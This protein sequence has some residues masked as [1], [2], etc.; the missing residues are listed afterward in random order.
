MLFCASSE[1]RPRRC[2][3]YDSCTLLHCC[4]STFVSSGLWS[5]DPDGM[6]SE[7]TCSRAPADKPP[8]AE[9]D[10]ARAPPGFPVPSP[11]F[12]PWAPLSPASAGYAHS[13]AIRSISPAIRSIICRLVALYRSRRRQ[14]TQLVN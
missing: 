2:L 3:D 13:P 4:G 8:C 1:F 9:L 11:W 10:G 6:N 5:L 12:P 7:D 14:A